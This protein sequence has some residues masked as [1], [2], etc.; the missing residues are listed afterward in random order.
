MRI[1]T[2]GYFLVFILLAAI[3]SPAA[4]QSATV[5]RL[6]A[7]DVSAFPRIIAY[8]D[9]HDAQG[10]FIDNLQ[11]NQATILE[12]EQ[13][14]PVIELTRLHPGL[15]IV[16]AIN[17]GAS[18][19][20][21][22]AQA[23]SRY[24]LVKEAIIAWAN[25]RQGST[26]DDWSYLITNGS[27]VSHTS[28]PAKW[29]TS[30]AADQTDLRA[31]QPSLD[32]LAKAVTLAADPP[33]RAGMGKAVLFITA[34]LEGEFDQALKDISDQAIQQ[35]VRISVWMVASSGAL[36]TQ[37]A[38]K[39]L[40]LVSATGGQAF[41]FS[42]D[43]AIP[44]PEAGFEAL[45]SVYRIAYVSKASSSGEHQ[46]TVQLQLDAE[47]VLA[48]SVPF[49]VDLQPP[50]PAFISPPI[51]IDRQS[52]ETGNQSGETAGFFTAADSMGKNSEELLLP[53][54]FTLQVVFDFPDRRVREIAR[55]ALLVDGVVVAEN[56]AAPFDRFNWD[57]SSYT[58][59]GVHRIQVQTTD[60][61]GLTGVSIEAPVQIN[62]SQP[63]VNPVSTVRRNLPAISGIIV[64]ISGALLFLVLI[65]GGHLHPAPQRAARAR[66]KKDLLTQS[67]HI[68]AAST[69]QK[70][71]WR[72]RLSSRGGA[73]DFPHALA[74]LKP[75]SDT[76]IQ[77]NSPSIPI[78]NEEMRLGSDPRRAALVLDDPC[79][80]G[81]HARLI[82]EGN[83][84][85]RLTDEGS[86][87]GTWVNYTP[88]DPR[89]V[90]L[91]HGD[92][93]HLGRLGF[94]FL[95]RQP[96]QPRKP[97]VTLAAAP[98]APADTALDRA[99]EDISAAEVELANATPDEPNR[100]NPEEWT[101]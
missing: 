4:A 59:A 24:D 50:Q 43:E 67:L 96:T 74:F 92:L 72:S 90:Y 18:F 85:F 55:S 61:L 47:Q 79:I 93:V 33:E 94:R 98:G 76:D 95:L 97:V 100:Q 11:L 3:S 56:T 70:S 25:S 34:P 83:D 39:L 5:A 64:L 29:A 91:Q 58:R 15:Q 41:V 35:G 10:Q 57:L 99:P 68:E 28:E 60:V 37:A 82:H 17:P 80:E 22:N 52:P 65:I 19:A 89:G 1:R 66:P 9:L 20:I 14:L 77:M 8:L 42:G 2:R 46:F 62:V 36:I 84:L 38:Q 27:S 6:S 45:R 81:L 23:L 88:V 71:G 32:T 12:G 44:D 13:T 48:N 53:R 73:Q 30:L 26:I 69:P 101:S 49:S 78:T 63:E 87:A 86:I 21:R 75:I 54:D 7:P 16:V 31:A 40:T 51:S